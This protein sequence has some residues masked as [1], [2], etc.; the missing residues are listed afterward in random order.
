MMVAVSLSDLAPGA[1]QQ[2]GCDSSW[3]NPSTTL[4]GFSADGIPLKG[5]ICLGGVI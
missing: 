2:F 4:G 3:L 5:E 1:G